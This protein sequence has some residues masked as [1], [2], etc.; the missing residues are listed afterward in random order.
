MAK[1]WCH[2]W[3]ILSQGKDDRSP[4]YQ[5]CVALLKVLV[6]CNEV[7]TV[8]YLFVGESSQAEDADEDADDDLCPNLTTEE[9]YSILD[10]TLTNVEAL[11]VN[12]LQ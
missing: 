3:V 11:L 7:G 6:T 10:K 1:L 2:L 4:R 9:L 8:P 12:L 5:F